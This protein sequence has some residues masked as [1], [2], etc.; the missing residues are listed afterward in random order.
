M[1]C[2]DLDPGRG[3]YVAPCHGG[4]QAAHLSPDCPR[5]RGSRGVEAGKLHDDF[6]VCSWCTKNVSRVTGRVA[7]SEADHGEHV[8]RTRMR[9]HTD[10]ACPYSGDG[11]R[12]P[13]DE[14]PGTATVCSHYV[15]ESRRAPLAERLRR[16][17]PE[18][19][20]VEPWP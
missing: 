11:E 9:V 5:L 15:D 10:P 7:L 19:L 20:G 8:W 13:A 14:V 6:P 2:G 16:A 4:V 3:V 17:D 1:K 18:E 12:V